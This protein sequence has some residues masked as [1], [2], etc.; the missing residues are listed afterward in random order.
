MTEF[1]FWGELTIINTYILSLDAKFWCLLLGKRIQ[2]C[3]STPPLFLS[4]RLELMVS[5]ED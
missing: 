1:C 3:V 4:V 5:L 2:C